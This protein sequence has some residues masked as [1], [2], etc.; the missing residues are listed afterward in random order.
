MAVSQEVTDGVKMGEKSR[1]LMQIVRHH[2]AIH[3]LNRLHTLWELRS[4]SDSER[5]F[6]LHRRIYQFEEERDGILSGTIVPWSG[7][8]RS[9]L[10]R[11]CRRRFQRTQFVAG[12]MGIELDTRTTDER[13]AQLREFEADMHQMELDETSGP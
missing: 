5:Y 13:E 4:M 11:S 7:T 9:K 8:T 1:A 10:L 2:E 6:A 12:E 3:S